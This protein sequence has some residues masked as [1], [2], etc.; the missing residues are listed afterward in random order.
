VRG[1]S[2]I[3]QN[4]MEEKYE[5]QRKYEREREEEKRSMANLTG[6]I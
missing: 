1:K 4:H 6:K 2:K 3:S 5:K